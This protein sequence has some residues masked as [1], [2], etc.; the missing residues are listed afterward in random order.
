MIKLTRHLVVGATDRIRYPGVKRIDPETARIVVFDGRGYTVSMVIKTTDQDATAI[1]TITDGSLDENGL[2]SI[3]VPA[4]TSELMVDSET[5]VAQ[6]F[7][8]SADIETH[9]CDILYEAHLKL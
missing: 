4:E 5:F 6:V 9:I 7:V 2:L 3:D 1:A 8:T